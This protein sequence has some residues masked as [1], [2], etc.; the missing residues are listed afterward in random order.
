MAINSFET[1]LT[2]GH[3][4]SLGNTVAVVEEIFAD[5]KKLQDLYDCYQSEDEVVRLRVSSGMKRVCKERP[6]W[7]LP[8]VDGLIADISKIDQASTK[9]TLSTLF[10][11][12]DEHMSDSQRQAAIKIM[13][14]NLSY[15]DWIVQNTTS[16]SLAHFAK[17]DD[18]LKKWLVPE[19]KKLTK[20]RHKSV[21]RRAEK[22]SASLQ[23]ESLLDE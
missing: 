10:M 5:K 21:A 15:D 12:L 19:L 22:L 13:K 3:P 9:W 4:N 2:G 14:A 1:K 11:W 20:S 8:F 6:E 18:D 16:E 17:K 7:V 23:K